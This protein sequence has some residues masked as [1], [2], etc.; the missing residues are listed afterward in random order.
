M[1]GPT[2]GN[3]YLA[4]A[5]PCRHCGKPI[6]TPSGKPWRG[7]VLHDECRPLEAAAQQAER[8]RPENAVATLMRALPRR[9]G[10]Q[11]ARN[12]PLDDATLARIERLYAAELRS[13]ADKVRAAER[14]R[15]QTYHDGSPSRSAAT[16]ETW[17]RAV[18]QRQSPL[19]RMF[20]LGKISMD[21]LEAARQIAAIVEMI[22]SDVMPGTS[23]F[24]M[25][26]DNAGAG[27]NA[28]VEGLM[29]VRLEV[30]YRAWSKT[31]PA[32][33]RM[34][35]DL[36]VYDNVSYVR[37]AAR[38]RLHWRTARKRLL[39]ALRI[40]HGFVAVARSEIDR[41]RLDAIHETI[42]RGRS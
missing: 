9:A 26:V 23:N 42:E 8:E 38:Y 24:E 29:R 17:E 16:L 22:E 25:P 37:T 27:R 13:Q 28:L 2:L 12:A 18:R 4:H 39:T 6:L 19:V 35:V 11:G 31:L 33:R 14:R 36:I 21:D 15:E 40:W 5:T 1:T 41:E 34:I 7:R 3:I 30:A 20:K 10:G 32:P